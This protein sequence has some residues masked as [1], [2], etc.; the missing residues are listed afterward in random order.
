MAVD[1]IIIAVYFVTI[2]GIGLASGRGEKSLEGYALG[3]RNVPWWAILASILAAEISAATFLGAPGEGFATRNFT[4]AQLA[5]GTVLGRIAV[6]AIFLKSYYDFQVVSIYEY[7]ERR[8]GP[9]TRDAASLVFL[10]T[11]ALASG[12][13]LY[14]AAILLVIGYEMV[15]GAPASP[16]TQFLLYVSALVVV[17]VLTAIYTTVGGIKAVIWTD[18]IQA[19]ILLLSLVVTIW[20][21]LHRIPGG[22]NGALA[23]LQQPGDLAFVSTG[24]EAGVGWWANIRN[25]LESNYTIFAAFIASTFIT[26]A[27]HGTDQDMVQRMLTGRNHKAGSLALIG[28]GLVDL[29]IVAAFLFIGILLWVFKQTHPELALP[30]QNPHV[31]PW[32]IM[33]EMPPVVRGLVFAGVM[34][35]AMGSLSTALNAL[36]TSFCRDWYLGHFRRQA[37]DAEMLRAARWA[38]AGF[39]V[40]L[41]VIGAAT[42]WIVIHVEGSRILPIVLGIFGYTYGSLLGVFLAGA[43]TKNRGSDRGNLIAMIA[44]FIVVAVLSG[45]P[46]DVLRILSLQPMRLPEWLPVIA[47]PWRI[48]F[49]SITTLVVAV[50][51]RTPARENS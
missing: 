21:L 43:L 19:S 37:D 3:D 11:R 40:V 18:V 26:M 48:F 41:I 4:Y 36:A 25:V 47:F 33:N 8:F 1:L 38:T 23:H 50:L 28:S 7:L 46:N 49:G 42:A 5:I 31:F 17:V 12:T 10:V 14:V 9:K 34:A 35:T 15:A 27:T 30:T 24:L 13:R 51:F 29:P 16:D 44:G 39:A 20:I 32:F 2:V 45:L 6:S 22:L